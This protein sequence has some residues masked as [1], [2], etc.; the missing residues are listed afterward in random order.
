MTSRLIR[1]FEDCHTSKFI[2][3]K[4]VGDFQPP[5]RLPFLVIADNAL[6]S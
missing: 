3:E 6:S 1:K 4:T 5:N 2:N